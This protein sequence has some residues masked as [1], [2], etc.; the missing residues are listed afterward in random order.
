MAWRRRC[1]E[2]CSGGSPGRGCEQ[3]VPGGSGED[4][5]RRGGRRGA[6]PVTKPGS[7][8]AGGAYI[9]TSTQETSHTGRVRAPMLYFMRLSI[10]F[11]RLSIEFQKTERASVRAARLSRNRVEGREPLNPVDRAHADE[12]MTVCAIS[13]WRDTRRGSSAPAHGSRV[14]RKAS[15]RAGRLSA[16]V[17]VAPSATGRSCRDARQC[18]RRETGT[19]HRSG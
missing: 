13:A 6:L 19:V 5:G 1:L 10:E 17:P 12:A 16:P 18:V 14:A 15:S 8:V 11:M 2:A 4:C 3:G 9:C 7:P